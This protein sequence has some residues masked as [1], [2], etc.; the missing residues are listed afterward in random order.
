[1]VIFGENYQKIGHKFQKT[2]KVFYLRIGFLSNKNAK[3]YKFRLTYDINRIIKSSVNFIM[4]K[5]YYYDYSSTYAPN[6]SNKSYSP[7][8]SNFLY[9]EGVN[10][11]PYI[12]GAL[13]AVLVV[14]FASLLMYLTK[15]LNVFSGKKKETAPGLD[16]EPTMDVSNLKGAETLI[17]E[18]E[19]SD[20]QRQEQAQ[21]KE[22]E[23]VKIVAS[24]LK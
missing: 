10:F 17:T 5:T 7:D 18:S 9:I 13:F 12:L 24:T 23:E 22:K 21:T 14:V 19:L 2:D 1:L 8:Y 20:A 15:G 16:N 4:S 6:Y 3:K 11:A